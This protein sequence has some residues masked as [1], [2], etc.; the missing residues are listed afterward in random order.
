MT[1]LIVEDYGIMYNELLNN[2]I[3]HPNVDKVNGAYQVSEA[4]DLFEE[5]KPDFLLLDIFIPTSGLSKEETNESQGGK[6]AG[7]IWFNNYVLNTDATWRN[8][9][10]I[11]SDYIS[12][13]KK[14]VPPDDLR[15]IKLLPKGNYGISDVISLF[16]EMTKRLNIK[17]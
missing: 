11:Y 8:K 16:T 5:D 10:I 9:I 7:W 1:V 17:E 13:L 6:L 4:M 12:I 14:N 3:D 2:F 15:G